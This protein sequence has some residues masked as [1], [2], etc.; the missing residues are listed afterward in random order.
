MIV[1]G[2]VILVR[3]EASNAGPAFEDTATE[4]LYQQM[5]C[6]RTQPGA[7]SPEAGLWALRLV[8]LAWYSG[9]GHTGSYLA[10]HEQNHALDITSRLDLGFV[11]DEPTLRFTRQS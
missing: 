4:G 10:V 2:V 6:Y 5:Q 11:A 7:K 8:S 9:A 3:Y 1:D